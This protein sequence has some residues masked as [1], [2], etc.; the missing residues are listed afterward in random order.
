LP[1]GLPRRV[2]ESPLKLTGS[3]IEQR[4]FLSFEGVAAAQPF[5][6]YPPSARLFAPGAAAHARC[7]AIIAVVGRINIGYVSGLRVYRARGFFL[8]PS[9]SA[10][11]YPERIPIP[12][13][14]YSELIQ[15][16][17]APSYKFAIEHDEISSPPL[18]ERKPA[19]MPRM[20]HLSKSPSSLP[21]CSSPRYSFSHSAS[22]RDAIGSRGP[23]L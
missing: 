18:R 10:E 22:P 1:G 17:P 16:Q 15:M 3:V 5:A 4:I 8:S 6:V 20:T 23:D 21:T 12:S 2:T 19:A 9:R 11:G 7:I 13:R 14:V